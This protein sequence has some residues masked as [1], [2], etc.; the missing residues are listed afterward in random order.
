[1]GQDENS[2]SHDIIEKKIHK[3]FQWIDTQLNIG[4]LILFYV[5][6][7]SRVGRSKQVATKENDSSEEMDMLQASSPVSD[8]TTQEGAEEEDISVGNVRRRSSKR[9]RRWTRH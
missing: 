3:L 4:I 1:M 9:E 6:F 2:L 7:F 8:D 5:F